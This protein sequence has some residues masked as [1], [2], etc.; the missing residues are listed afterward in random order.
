MLSRNPL[1]MASNSRR[2]SSYMSALEATVGLV[3][4][5]SQLENL[6]GRLAAASPLVRGLLPGHAD[7]VL[8]RLRD[9]KPPALLPTD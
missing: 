5:P 4:Y 3:R 2:A 7:P 9:L 1:L 6:F 8:L